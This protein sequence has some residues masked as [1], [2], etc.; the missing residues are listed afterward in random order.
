[1]IEIE[2]T[3]RTTFVDRDRDA[4]YTGPGT[5]E[6]ADE[7]AEE[8]LDR[9]CWE[10]PEDE[11]EDTTEAGDEADGEDAGSAPEA[12]DEDF[13]NL[14]GVGDTIAENLRDAGYSSFDD[15]HRAGSESLTEVDGITESKVGEIHDQLDESGE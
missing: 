15:L 2:L 1:M 10:R 11:D 8:Y 12:G 13:T 14:D 3:R 7:A 6:V 9:S 5:F 4:A